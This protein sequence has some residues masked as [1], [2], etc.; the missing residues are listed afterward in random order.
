MKKIDVAKLGK[1]VG[2]HGELKIYLLSDFPEQFKKGVS[3]GLGSTNL[4][5]QSYNSKSQT[6]KFEKINTREKARTLTNKILTQTIEE[7]RK[8]CELKDGEYF[9]FDIIGLSVIEDNEILGV[10]TDII[11]RPPSHL[12]EI[13]TDKNILVDKI[14]KTFLCPYVKDRYILGVDLQNKTLTTKDVK[15]LMLA[16]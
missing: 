9:W 16:Q 7:T 1:S 10:V 8:N 13:E 15:E 14:P 3:F 5:I 6:V 2:L 12:L 4:T 11:E